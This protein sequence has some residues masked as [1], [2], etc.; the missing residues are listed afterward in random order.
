MSRGFVAESGSILNTDT[1]PAYPEVGSRFLGHRTVERARELAGPNGENNNLAEE[2][3]GRSALLTS[4]S[5]ASRARFS[6]SPFRDDGVFRIS[7]ILERVPAA[8]AAP[9]GET[10]EKRLKN[11][12]FPQNNGPM[13]GNTPETKEP[14]SG[15][16][17]L[18]ISR[19]A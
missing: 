9:A 19:E 18:G 10:W 11:R 12:P 17:S 4:I 5:P 3:H 13:R 16:G 2:L 14:R 1:S 15:R 6:A 8:K 7:G